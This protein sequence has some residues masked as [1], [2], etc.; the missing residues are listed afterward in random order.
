[1]LCAKDFHLA[2]FKSQEEKIKRLKADAVPTIDQDHTAGTGFPLKDAYILKLKNI[3]YLHGD[4]RKGEITE[5]IDFK[6]LNVSL[7]HTLSVF[8]V[9][10]L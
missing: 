8:Y 10:S 4:D 5:N 3:L 9:T 2:C 7:S 1:M 6:Y